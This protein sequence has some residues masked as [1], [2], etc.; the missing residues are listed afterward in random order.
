MQTTV[1]KIVEENPAEQL[2]LYFKAP[3]S[4]PIKLLSFA[5]NP[6]RLGNARKSVSSLALLDLLYLKST[7][8]PILS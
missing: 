6:L 3:E 7:R 8:R 4:I 2:D 5:P 1:C